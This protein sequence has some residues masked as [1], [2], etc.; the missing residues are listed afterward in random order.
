MEQKAFVTVLIAD[1]EPSIRNGLTTAIPWETIPAVVTGLASDGEEA[2]SFIS[3]NTPD[4]AVVDIRMPKMNGL[5]LIEKTRNAGFTTEFIIL[6][7]Y[8]DFSFAQKA[9]RF[10]VKAY[11]LK[12]FKKDDL[13]NEV[14]AAAERIIERRSTTTLK[15][16]DLKELKESSAK[17]FFNQLVRN[18][19]NEPSEL[20]RKFKEFCPE[21]TDVSPLCVIVFLIHAANSSTHDI[22]PVERLQ[23]VIKEKLSDKPYMLWQF[24]ADHVIA[25]LQ[26]IPDMISFT[27]KCIRQCCPEHDSHISAGIGK[28]IPSLSECHSSYDSALLALSYQLYNSDQAVFDCSIICS[29]VPALSAGSIHTEPL[30]DAICRNDVPAITSYCENFFH[31]LFYT[32][33][34][35]PGFVKGMCIF[36]ITDIQKSLIKQTGVDP[37]S[38]P[39][40]AYAEINVLSS[41]ADIKDWMTALFIRYSSETLV[42]TANRQDP[43]I[44]KAKQYI[45]THIETKIR[46]EDVAAIVNQSAAY[47]PIYFKSKTGINFRD[48]MLY[49]RNE[50]AKQ[51]LTSVHIPINE[52][53]DKLGYEDYRSF[54]RAFK[55]QTGI[56]P[57]E[58]Q[59]QYDIRSKR[60]RESHT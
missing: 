10:G 39:E 17:I 40:I 44:E 27:E 5:D 22:I 48:Y 13:I 16:T 19:I 59:Q 36:L 26:T 18:E 9:I 34:P 4:I 35:P 14:S 8:D 46:A 54:C 15:N 25:I 38:F 43:F 50:Y 53:S 32:P 31:S 33:M 24:D 41:F 56:T 57:S 7:G 51:L 60:S 6:S 21:M 29:Q 2:F 52:I 3:S 12:P 49:V 30:L 55:K 1:D 20:S 11:L 28:Q 47:F 58:Y 45:Q 37:S 23:T 42:N